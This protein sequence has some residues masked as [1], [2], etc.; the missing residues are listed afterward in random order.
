M[1]GYES[2]FGLELL[3]SVDWIINADKTNQV[4]A[5]EVKQKI[6]QWSKRKAD[7]FSSDHVCLAIKRLVE[8]S[9]ELNYSFA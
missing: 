2:P 7:N 4:S 6:E 5:I 1:A 3:A 8:F 9:K